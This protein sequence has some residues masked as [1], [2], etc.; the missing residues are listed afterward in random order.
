MDTYYLKYSS[1]L[2][3][4]GVTSWKTHHKLKISCRKCIQ[5]TNP[6]EHHSLA[7]FTLTAQ[8]AYVCSQLSKSI[9]HKA[10]FVR[11][12]WIAHVISWLLYWKWETEWVYGHRGLWAH[13]A[14][15]ELWLTAAAQCRQRG[16]GC[17]LLA[18]GKLTPHNLKDSFYWMCI[19]FTPSESWK[20]ISQGP[21]VLNSFH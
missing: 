16:S 13:V 3:Y 20:I 9:S 21:S 7:S 18:W 5:Y 2:T 14:D 19:A 11:K 1:S 4:N 15:G 17:V 10:Y 6:I 8:N 12:C